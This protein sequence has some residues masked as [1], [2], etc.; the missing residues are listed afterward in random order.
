MLGF[1]AEV[2]QEIKQNVANSVVSVGE[3]PLTV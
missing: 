1:V 2:R 3:E